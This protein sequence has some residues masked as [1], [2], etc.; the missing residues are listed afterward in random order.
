M[1]VVDSEQLPRILQCNIVRFFDRV[2]RPGL[3]RLEHWPPEV[4]G[5]DASFEA[6]LDRLA[7]QID[8]HTADEAR[9]AFALA[10]AGTFERQLRIFAK[11]LLPEVSW[12]TIS[13]GNVV[14]LLKMVAGRRLVDLEEAGL[15]LI[16]A[17]LITLANAVRHGDGDACDTL[18]ETSPRFWPERA[19][20]PVMPAALATRSELICVRDSDLR[21]YVQAMVRFWGLADRLQGNVLV[22]PV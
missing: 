22:A 17:E 1:R 11:H 7:R 20:D 14:K 21:L 16:L 9:R 10:L 19:D 4:E 6:R 13:K 18:G 15:G 2:I 12:E 5:S 3:E 8:D